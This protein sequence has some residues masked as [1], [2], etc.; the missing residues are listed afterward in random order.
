MALE[1][2]A[3]HMSCTMFNQFWRLPFLLSDGE[4]DEHMHDCHKLSHGI[5]NSGNENRFSIISPPAHFTTWHSPALVLFEPYS[6]NTQLHNPFADT[7]VLF[8][9]WTSTFDLITW[10][11]LIPHIMLLW[12]CYVVRPHRCTYLLHIRIK[13]PK[14]RSIYWRI[15]LN[16]KQTFSAIIKIESTLCS[17]LPHLFFVFFL[18]P[19][20][21]THICCDIITYRFLFYVLVCCCCSC[22]LLPQTTCNF[23]L[24]NV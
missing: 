23:V 10:H 4:G 15:Y 2:I 5:Q 12:Q 14:R 7:P 16:V 6:V 8:V 1:P 21:R 20:Y 17:A 13:Y 24:R 11:E 22:A 18:I 9:H 3:C 19:L